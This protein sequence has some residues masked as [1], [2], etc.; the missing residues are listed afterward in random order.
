LIEVPFVEPLFSI[1]YVFRLDLRTQTN[2]IP[3]SME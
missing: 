1:I 2:S 3:L